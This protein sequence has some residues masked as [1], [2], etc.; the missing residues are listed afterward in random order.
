MTLPRTP[1]VDFD[2]HVHPKNVSLSV[3]PSQ[4]IFFSYKPMYHKILQTCTKF[5]MI[6][7]NGKSFLPSIYIHPILTVP[8][9]IFTGKLT[10][11]E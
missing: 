6:E 1:T 5:K 8:K 2:F 7:C 9:S 3:H 11:I 10:M 4:N